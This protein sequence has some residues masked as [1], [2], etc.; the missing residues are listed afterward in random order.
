MATEDQEINSH[1]E[2]YRRVFSNER[3]AAEEDEEEEE[4]E[5]EERKQEEDPIEKIL[6]RLQHD[7]EIH[8]VS[9]CQRQTVCK[10]VAECLCDDDVY[11]TAISTRVHMTSFLFTMSFGYNQKLPPHFQSSLRFFHLLP[12]SASAQDHEHVLFDVSRD[13]S[14]VSP[15]IITIFHQKGTSYRFPVHSLLCTSHS[16]DLSFEYLQML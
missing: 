7:L 9:V 8:P 4:E 16:L 6:A 3:L 15:W 12:S 11:S 2:K 14:A 13:A 10:C 1:L 5:E